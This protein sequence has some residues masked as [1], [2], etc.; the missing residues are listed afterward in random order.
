MTTAP[1]LAPRAVV[2]PPQ[3]TAV[4]SATPAPAA[5]AA[6]LATRLRSVDALRGFDMFWIIGAGALV[7]ALDR[8]SDNVVTRFLSTQLKHVQ[9]EGLHCYDII[10][11]LFL[12]LVGVSIVLSVDKALP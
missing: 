1:E 7:H 8:M 6:P 5:P 3:E 4:T 9:W 10:F 12:F 11:P 2:P